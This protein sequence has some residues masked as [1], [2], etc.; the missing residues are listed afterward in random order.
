MNLFVILRGCPFVYIL[1]FMYPI[2]PLGM[3]GDYVNI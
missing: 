3:L 2:G 1:I